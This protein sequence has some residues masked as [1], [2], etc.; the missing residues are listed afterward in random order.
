MVVMEITGAKRFVGGRTPLNRETL[1][2]VFQ[3]GSRNLLRS[4]GY[5]RFLPL[6]FLWR[7]GK[8]CLRIEV[9]FVAFDP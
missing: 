9:L 4:L 6:S 8:L 7:T 5:L 2:V 3:W 1:V